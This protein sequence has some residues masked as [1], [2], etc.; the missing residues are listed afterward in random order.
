MRRCEIDGCGRKHRARGL[1]HKHYQRVMRGG[2]FSLDDIPPDVA[3]AAEHEA[4]RRFLFAMVYLT[5]S[6]DM[7]RSA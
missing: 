1:C 4:R 2:K 7:R 5:L 3:E 6:A